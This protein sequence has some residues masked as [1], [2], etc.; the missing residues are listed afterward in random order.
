VLHTLLEEKRS[1]PLVAIERMAG[2][3][4]GYKCLDE[5]SGKAGGS[6]LLIDQDLFVYIV[7]RYDGFSR[8]VEQF[9]AVEERAQYIARHTHEINLRGLDMLAN[10]LNLGKVHRRT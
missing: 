10:Q 4:R 8:L 7:E 9:N 3:L 2:F 6:S 5:E 1:Q